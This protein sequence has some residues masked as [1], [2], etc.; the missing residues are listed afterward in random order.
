MIN[1]FNSSKISS[2]HMKLR[3]RRE[4]I[5]QLSSSQL[6]NAKGGAETEGGWSEEIA[7]CGGSDTCKPG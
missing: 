5:A 1:K 4:I 2:R 7:V 6:A 3:L